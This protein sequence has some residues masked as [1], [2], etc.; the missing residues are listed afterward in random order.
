MPVSYTI[1]WRRY[2]LILRI[3]LTLLK[4]AI[5]EDNAGAQS[6]MADFSRALNDA[7]RQLRELLTTFR[8]TLQQADLPSALHEMLEDLQSQTPARLTLDWPFTHAGAGCAN[9]GAFVANCA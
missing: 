9:A 1:R 2:F 7:Y 8:L 3:Q 5:P 4:R 6:I